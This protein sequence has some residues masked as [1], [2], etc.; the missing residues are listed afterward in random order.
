MKSDQARRLLR[1]LIPNYAIRIKDKDNNLIDIID[2][3]TPRRGYL[4]V[5]LQIQVNAT[6]EQFSQAFMD[7]ENN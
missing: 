7:K 5:M 1:E 6:R 4:P 2:V 3:D